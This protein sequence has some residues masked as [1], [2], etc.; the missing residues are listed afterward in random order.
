MIVARLIRENNEMYILH[1]DGSKL[2]AGNKEIRE[3]LLFFKNYNLFANQESKWTNTVKRLERYP[4]DIVAD[5]EIRE[6]NDQFPSTIFD[7]E[8]DYKEITETYEKTILTIYD[9]FILSEIANKIDSFEYVTTTEYGKAYNRSGSDIRKYCLLGRI[10][11]AFRINKN[12][13][14]VP[15]NAPYPDDLRSKTKKNRKNKS[16]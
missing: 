11:G 3:F 13:W 8:N 12:L 7:V 15:K 4:G 9:S 1:N 16:I 5:I 14:L 10:P 6:F 2:K